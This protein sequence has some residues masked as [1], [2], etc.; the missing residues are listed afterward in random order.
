MSFVLMKMTRGSH[1]ENFT[2]SL[3][4]TIHLLPLP[5]APEL[6]LETQLTLKPVCINSFG[7]FTRVRC[8]GIFYYRVI[9]FG[10]R[11]AILSHGPSFRR[12]LAQDPRARKA[13]TADARANPV[14]S[15]PS[16]EEP[17]HLFPRPVL[18]LRRR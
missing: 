14:R 11:S 16:S 12:T 10:K 2:N 1:S 6:K 5:R 8:M 4:R 18:A 3:A 13:S 7:S 9:A 15:T 17:P